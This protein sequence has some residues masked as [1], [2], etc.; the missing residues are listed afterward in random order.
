M[1]IRR[2]A[3]KTGN[4]AYQVYWQNPYTKK[5]ESKEFDLEK[6]A[7]KYND[8]VLY[9][10]KYE[11]H[12]FL[13]QDDPSILTVED[14][15][16]NYLE[17]APM[18]PT[19]RKMSWYKAKQISDF[20]GD[21]IVTKLERKNFVALEDTLL[22]LG[23]KQNTVQRTMSILTAAI[24]WAIRRDAIDYDMPKYSCRRGPDA[25]FQPPTVEEAA[26]II[27]AAP[28]HI[29]RAVILTWH[30]GVRVGP[31]ELFKVAWQGVDWI[32]KTIYFEAAKKNRRV[33][34]RKLHISPAFLAKL[35]EWHEQ[36]KEL[37]VMPETIVHY[38]SRPIKSMKKAWKATLDR[39]KIKR[40]IRPYDLRHAFATEAL[41]RGADIKA[42]SEVMGHASPTMILQH[43]QHVMGHQ[44]EQAV[45]L[46]P[47]IETKQ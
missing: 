40:R 45:N 13:P 5:Q 15:L 24:N 11:R 17:K 21:R 44:K 18:T 8:G 3:R 27:A 23:Q 33:A 41:A 12:T 29:Q 22:A 9:R 39:A 16:E 31:S 36:D 47:E 20:I 42:V 14:L 10:L 6:D 28:P 2:K 30:L 37:K 4:T 46:V 35:T 7:V 26:R 1:A 19:T 34:W 38:H 25:Q 43:Y 32:E